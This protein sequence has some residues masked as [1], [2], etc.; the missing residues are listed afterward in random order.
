MSGWESGP[1]NYLKNLHGDLADLVNGDADAAAP[2]PAHFEISVPRSTESNP[3]IFKN[4]GNDESA[5]TNFS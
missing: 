3:P 4:L 2:G 1:P 5:N